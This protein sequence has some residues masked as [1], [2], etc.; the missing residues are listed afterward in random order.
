MGSRQSMERVAP[1]REVTRITVD[2]NLQGWRDGW[3]SG[4]EHWIFF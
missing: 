4:Y 1:C 2:K 3:F